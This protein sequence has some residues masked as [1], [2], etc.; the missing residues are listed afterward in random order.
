MESLSKLE[1]FRSLF[2]QIGDKYFFTVLLVILCNT[3]TL[4]NM[5]FLTQTQKQSN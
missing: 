2:S 4:L 3:Q 1:A 5:I